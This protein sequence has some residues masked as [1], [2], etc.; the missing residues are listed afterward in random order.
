MENEFFISEIC[1]RYYWYGGEKYVRMKTKECV[2]CGHKNNMFNSAAFPPLKPI[3]VTP[4][5][6]WR[7][8]VDLAGPLPKTSKGNKYIAIAICAFSK[9]IEARG[10]VPIH[11]TFIYVSHSKKH[12]IQISDNTGPQA[13]SPRPRAPGPDKI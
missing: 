13:P 11:Y 3:P 10:N 4:K 9:Y 1:M 8:H 12:E 2:I 6:F 7:V 5:L